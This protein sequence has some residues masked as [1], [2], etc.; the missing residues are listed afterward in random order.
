VH[1]G[2]WL[3]A[4]ARCK[5]R[6]RFHFPLQN[7]IWKSPKKEENATERRNYYCVVPQI[8][9]QSRLT[10]FFPENCRQK[11]A[12]KRVSFAVSFER[13]IARN[14]TLKN[15]RVKVTT[16]PVSNLLTFFLYRAIINRTI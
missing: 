7:L 13:L 2:N 15:C 3:F 10:P 11:R 4:D 16:S 6:R 5:R 1:L 8:Q 14:F 9:S 12:F